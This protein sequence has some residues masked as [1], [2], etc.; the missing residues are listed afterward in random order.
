MHYGTLNC[1]G[2]VL[3]MA[4]VLLSIVTHQAWSQTARKASAMQRVTGVMRARHALEPL[5]SVLAVRVYDARGAEL[6]GVPVQWTLSHAGDG[7]ALRVMNATTDSLGISRTE[8]IP[9]RS[10]D[11]QSA[12][13]EVSNVGRIAFAVTIPAARLRIVPARM[14]LWSGDDSVM[15][16]ELRDARGTV[17]A[18][19]AVSWAVMD[20]T[21][22]RV[23]PDSSAGARVLGVGGGTTQVAA[24]VGDGKIRDIARATVRAV[25]SGRVITIDAAV[26]PAVRIEVRGAGRRDSIPVRDARFAARFE[27]PLGEAI[28]IHVS[29][30]DTTYHEVAVRIDDERELERLVIALI[31]KSFRIEAGPHE[32]QEVAIDAATA[33][34]RVAGTAPFWRLVPYSGT[35]PRKLLG[36]RESVLP[37]HIAF[38]REP[39]SETIT[40]ADSIAF[41][42]T[43]RRM[44][45]DV[46]RSLFMAADASSDTAGLGFIRVVVRSQ[47]AEGHTFVAWSQSGD[48]S[49]GTLTFRRAAVLRDPHVVTHELVHLL[50]FGHSGSWP[51]VAQPSGGTQSGLTPHDVAYIQLAMKLRRLQEATGARPGVPVLQK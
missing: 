20:T 49:E 46:G 51:T 45:R 11:V 14:T 50:G 29:P 32:G 17:L 10:A 15:V 18:G 6:A 30:E 42:E 23:F 27:V 7:A 13:A 3:A 47:G 22:A 34:A 36:W 12:I 48:A 38:A 26:P 2:G 4:A 35:G 40:A 25:I 5:D 8:L 21:I 9:G 37:L 39:S 1:M 44:E 43:A 19:G 33:M 24:W 41:W 28:T 16:A 31:P